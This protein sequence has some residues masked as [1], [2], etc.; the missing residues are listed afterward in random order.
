MTLGLSAANRQV[1]LCSAVMLHDVHCMPYSYCGTPT[2]AADSKST[3]FFFSKM[4]CDFA[5]LALWTSVWGFPLATKN[6][7]PAIFIGKLFSYR[8]GNLETKS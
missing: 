1:N 8:P 3:G 5:G 2:A 7:T 4:L 6:M